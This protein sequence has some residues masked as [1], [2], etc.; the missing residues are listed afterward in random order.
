[1]GCVADGRGQKVSIYGVFAAAVTVT[2]VDGGTKGARWLTV[3]ELC[4]PKQATAPARVGL[5]QVSTAH[6]Q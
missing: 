3:A 5:Q 6:E 2:Y 1:M 4:V